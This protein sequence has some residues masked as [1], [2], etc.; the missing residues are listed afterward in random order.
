VP[1]SVDR[2]AGNELREIPRQQ[3]DN[4]AFGRRQRHFNVFPQNGAVLP[5]R[6]RS[7]HDVAPWWASLL[8]D[9]LD[10]LPEVSQ[11]VVNSKNRADVVDDLVT[12]PSGRPACQIDDPRPDAGIA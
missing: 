3:L 9:G 11:H 12:R 8:A 4:R 5:Q 1:E 2:I 7:A 6:Q 10:Q